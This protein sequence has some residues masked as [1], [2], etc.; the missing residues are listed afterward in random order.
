MKLTISPRHIKA[1]LPLAG[2][3]DAR[4]YLNGIY[5]EANESQ[6]RIV[7][8]N[9]VCL[10]VIRSE[11]GIDEAESVTII[12]PRH[13]A[14][15]LSKLKTE[16]IL[17]IGE[18]KN[19]GMERDCTAI[20]EKGPNVGFTSLDGEYPQWRKV[21]SFEQDVEAAP[22]QF[23]HKYL[24]AFAKTAKAL[25]ESTGS[26]LIWQ[27]G[28]DSAGVYVQCERDFFGVLMPLRDQYSR[29]GTPDWAVETL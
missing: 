2:K 17:E 26:I 9:G 3:D 29:S 13:V 20:S 25:G 27:R 14:E 7:A 16:F 10:G 24:A 4:Y 28:E 5:I 11:F 1:L 21:V 15:V 23:A 8:C 6:S 22:A 19:L 18:K 12:I